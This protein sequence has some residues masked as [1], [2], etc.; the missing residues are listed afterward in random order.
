FGGSAGSL[1]YNDGTDYQDD[2]TPGSVVQGSAS[3]PILDISTLGG[4]VLLSF[5]CNYETQTLGGFNFDA[6][7]VNIIDATSG[8]VVDQRIFA[9]DTSGGP[10]TDFC[11][12]RGTYHQHSIDIS[13]VTTG[14]S[15]IIVQ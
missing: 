11:A 10:P 15:S 13:G 6:R 3:S 5:E 9:T 7:R 12:T 1:N 14:L 2:G 8:V 4:T